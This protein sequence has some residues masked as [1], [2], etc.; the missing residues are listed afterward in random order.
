MC[1]CMCELLSANQST[2]TLGSEQQYY[3]ICSNNRRGAAGLIRRDRQLHKM[4]VVTFFFTLWFISRQPCLVCLGV[5]FLLL[6]SSGGPVVDSSFFISIIPGS[7]KWRYLRSFA[8]PC[9][10]F[11]FDGCLAVWTLVFVVL[12]PHIYAHLVVYCKGNRQCCL[13]RLIAL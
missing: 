5:F 13:Q 1:V 7:K 12:E 9:S 8:L 4:V 6:S 2:S 11:G 10:L 3:S